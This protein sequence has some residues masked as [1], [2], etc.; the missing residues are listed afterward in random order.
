MHLIIAVCIFPLQG[1]L[2][3]LS[4]VDGGLERAFFKK[5]FLAKHVFN[6]HTSKAM[7][8]ALLVRI[9]SFY[10]PPPPHQQQEQS[11]RRKS[12]FSVILLN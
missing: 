2:P 5:A 12:Q 7:S 3:L 11:K 8:I 9:F 4:K 10:S 6:I 1:T